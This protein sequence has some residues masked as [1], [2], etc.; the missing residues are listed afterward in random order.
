MSG[1]ERIVPQVARDNANEMR[2]IALNI[3]QLLEQV[4]AKMQLINDEDTGLYQGYRKPSQL[5]AE[6][7][8][9]RQTFHLASD[10]IIKSAKD[11]INT[12]N[13]MENQ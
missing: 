12:A 2:N 10:Q 1:Q 9:F 11:I 8:S 7:D 4:S 3:E 13:T 6:L 5:R